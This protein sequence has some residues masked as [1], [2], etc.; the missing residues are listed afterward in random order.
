MAFVGAEFLLP[1]E[2]ANF[3]ETGALPDQRKKCLVCCRY[4][5]HYVYILVQLALSRPH[6]L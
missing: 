3:L 4:Y 5:Q 1:E 6:P 2:R